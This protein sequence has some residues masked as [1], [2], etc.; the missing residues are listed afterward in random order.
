MPVMLKNKIKFLT[1]IL[2]L[3]FATVSL[4]GLS[5]FIV[6][7]AYAQSTQAECEAAGRVWIEGPDNC[8]AGTGS[9]EPTEELVND[10]CNAAVPQAD[11]NCRLLLYLR[12]GINF[13]S[14]VAGMAIVFSLM[15]AGY[16]YI[17]ARDNPNAVS[18]AKNRIVMTIIA[19]L[20]FIFMYAILNFLIPGGLL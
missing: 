5:A 3:L 20:L 15:W 1:G 16:E 11:N 19:L 14:A 9:S 7:P 17:T 8:V 18:G 4:A 12:N 13:L 10:Q 6:N 2:C